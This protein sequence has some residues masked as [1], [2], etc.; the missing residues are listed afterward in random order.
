MQK[1]V[2]YQLNIL[3]TLAVTPAHFINDTANK[4]IESQASAKVGNFL[5]DVR[6]NYFLVC[7]RHDHPDPNDFPP[8]PIETC[9]L[10]ILADISGNK[11][12]VQVRDEI[13]KSN[14][15]DCIVRD[16]PSTHCVKHKSFI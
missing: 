10:S 2:N 3:A 16:I 15:N 7:T 6:P 5:T 12:K 4:T 8:V 9:A 11:R 1:E 14:G 13:V